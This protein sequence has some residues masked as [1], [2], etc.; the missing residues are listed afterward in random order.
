MI[1]IKNILESKDVVDFLLKRNLLDQYKKSKY[2]II[3]WILAKTDFKIRQPKSEWIWSF[4]IND[5]FRAFWRIDIE[6][7]LI[8]YDIDN[9]QNY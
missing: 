1:K 9:H 3:N 5:Q 6:W 2:Y 7:N 4:R 8:I